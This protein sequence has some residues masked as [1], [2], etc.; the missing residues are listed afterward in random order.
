MRQFDDRLEIESPGRLPGLVRVQNIQNMRFSRN[1]HIARVLAEMTGYVRELNEGV[2]RMF[3]EMEQH[4]LRAPVFSVGEG[5]VRVTLYKL[6]EETLPLSTEGIEATMAA[7]RKGIN[8]KRLEPLLAALKTRQQ[9]PPQEIMALLG[10]TPPTVRNYMRI[11][12]REGL[13]RFSTQSRTNP[14]AQ[15]IVS[16]APFWKLLEN[17]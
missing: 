14:T 15:W 11:L 8:N 5:N 7:L 10:V 3:E 12:E 2:R 9:M 6:P 1:P 17:N 16:E 13:V 4:G